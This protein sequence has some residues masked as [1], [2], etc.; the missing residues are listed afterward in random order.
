MCL[1]CSSLLMQGFRYGLLCSN[2][3]ARTDSQRL[4][5]SIS[6]HCQKGSQATPSCADGDNWSAIPSSGVSPTPVQFR[7]SLRIA[8][9]MQECRKV[10]G[11]CIATS[12]RGTNSSPVP[13]GGTM[14]WV[15]SSAKLPE[16]VLAQTLYMS[17]TKAN[18]VLPFHSSPIFHF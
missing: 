14:T 7:A 16:L 2:Y 18:F 9:P 15:C 13:L 3:K 8:V 4:L 11:I 5:L 1:V 6:S 17:T 10:T 12:P